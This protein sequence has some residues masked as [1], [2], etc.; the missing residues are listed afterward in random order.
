MYQATCSSPEEKKRARGPQ[1][2]KRGR[3]RNKK[4]FR[5]T[6]YAS[7]QE[8]GVSQRRW[9]GR[10]TTSTLP[11]SFFSP[12]SHSLPLFLS[13][14]FLR[15]STMQTFSPFFKWLKDDSTYEMP[16]HHL[17]TVATN[18]HRQ[19]IWHKYFQS[20]YKPIHPT[21]SMREREGEKLPVEARLI[22]KC[23]RE[24]E[25]ERR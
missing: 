23:Q 16:P 1:E 6:K 4:M 13:L 17:A 25:R 18:F 9:T 12:L 7:G 10:I 19:H 8:E 22:I 11:L 20:L 21:Q 5:L 3:G 2:S 14:S 15:R 24:R